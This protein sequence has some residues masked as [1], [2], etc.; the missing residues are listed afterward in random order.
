M[1]L[2]TPIKYISNKIN[3]FSFKFLLFLNNTKMPTPLP[4][5]NP[6]IAEPNVI[7]PFR[8]NSVII[9]LALQLGI[10]PT[11]LDINDDNG[12]FFKNIFEISSSPK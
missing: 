5:N 9:I 11:I 12:L 2:I 4:V 7:V 6:A 3:I 1:P 8:Y 10:K